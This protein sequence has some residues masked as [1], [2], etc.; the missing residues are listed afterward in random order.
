MTRR[1]DVLRRKQAYEDQKAQ[2]DSEVQ[3]YRRANH[4]ATNDLQN[5]IRSKI[6]VTSL[7]LDISAQPDFGGRIRVTINNGS[8]PHDSQALNWNYDVTLSGSGEVKKESG[9]WSGLSATTTEQINNLKESVRVIEILNNIDWKKVLQVELPDYNDFVKSEYPKNENFNEQLLEADVLDAADQGYLI[10]GHGDKYNPR[11]VMFYQVLKVNP[12]SFRVR[13]IPEDN[14]R[15]ESTW[16]DP[17]TI[18][19]QEFYR[20]IDNP[21]QTVEV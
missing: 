1:D 12:K 2:Y 6:G 16:G 4:A 14:V 19:K 8:N 17:F 18:Q 13:A 21:V 3:S 5:L 11:V 15:D 20:L 9:S 7:D 10:K